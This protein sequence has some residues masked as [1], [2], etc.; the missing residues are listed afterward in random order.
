MAYADNRGLSRNPYALAGTVAIQAAVGVALVAG[1]GV[2][3]TPMIKTGPMPSREYKDPPPP[4]PTP[5]DPQPKVKAQQPQATTEKPVTPPTVFELGPVS[6]IIDTT[7][8]IPNSLPDVGNI[9]HPGPAPQP[10]LQAAKPT[11]AAPRN[12]PSEWVTRS[13][14]R[15][16]WVREEMSGTVR[17]ELS[18]GA[19][20]K[21]SDCRI[22]RSSGHTALDQATCRLVTKRAKFKSAKNQFG[23]KVSSTYANTVLWQIPD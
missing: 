17:F 1:L 10:G 23:E 20:G 4:K 13:D 22:L 16:R 8:I 3:V 9:A 7:T 15:P 18:I 12:D 2:T 14:Y 5:D 6:P 21:I 11:A 19:D